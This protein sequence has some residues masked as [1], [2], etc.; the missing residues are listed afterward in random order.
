MG[1][2]TLCGDTNTIDSLIS[3]QTKIAHEKI[4]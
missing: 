4:F 1:C 2:G 3:A